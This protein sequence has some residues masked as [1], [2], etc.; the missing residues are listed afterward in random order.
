MCISFG[1]LRTIIQGNCVFQ[2][3]FL[4]PAGCRK[5]PSRSSKFPSGACLHTLTE[6]LLDRF[7]HL[8]EQSI[9]RCSTF[10]PENLQVLFIASGHTRCTCC[11]YAKRCQ[12]LISQKMLNLGDHILSSIY[13]GLGHTLNFSWVVLDANGQRF[14]FCLA[15]FSSTPEKFNGHLGR[16]TQH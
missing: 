11:M 5:W 3:H 12:F 16:K 4:P 7:V 8:H 15:S 9:E 2:S 10:R 6:P 13:Q 14:L 1:L